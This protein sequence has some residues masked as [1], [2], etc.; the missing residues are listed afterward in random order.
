MK[1]LNL[2]RLVRPIILFA[3]AGTPVLAQVSH[4]RH[5]SLASHVI[6]PH[7]R[8]FTHQAGTVQITEVN[9]AIEILEGVATTT[10]DLSLTNGTGARYGVSS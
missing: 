10:L 4:D 6:M 2:G 7:A 8:P 3:L 1:I 5:Q 9:A